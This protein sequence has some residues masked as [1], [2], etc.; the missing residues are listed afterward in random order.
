[1]FPST[2]TEG[3]LV[4]QSRSDGLVDERKHGHASRNLSAVSSIHT[5]KSTTS[6]SRPSV[7]SK[8]LRYMPRAKIV[9]DLPKAH[10]PMWA[11]E[12]IDNT[13]KSLHTIPT[14]EGFSTFRCRKMWL[15]IHS[16]GT[17]ILEKFPNSEVMPH[18]RKTRGF[19]HS[20]IFLHISVQLHLGFYWAGQYL[21]LYIHIYI[22]YTH[23]VISMHIIHVFVF[24]NSMF[25]RCRI[26]MLR[27]PPW[28]LETSRWFP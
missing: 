21:Y 6:I 28:I 1:M 19:W 2:G 4:L 24:S 12:T 13:L 16:N 20:A 8:I 27:V 11:P 22:Y 14:F 3:A 15:G 17:L 25:K 10:T 5:A 9:A 7:Q 18:A 26:T 23:Y